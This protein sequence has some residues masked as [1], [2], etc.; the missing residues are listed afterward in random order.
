MAESPDREGRA[1]PGHGGWPAW[2]DEDDFDGL[3]EDAWL[4]AME[5]LAE[6]GP[7]PECPP[8]ASVPDA[9]AS[10]V[11]DGGGRD[12]GH[13]DAGQPDD[14]LPD[15]YL[16]DDGLRGGDGLPGGPG[17]PVLGFGPGDA[18][19]LMPPG[20]SLG[21][22]AE[23]AVAGGG[24]AVMSDYEVIG[25]AAAARRQR[26]RSD[27]LELQAIGEFTRRRW[28]S[29]ATAVR[30]ASGRWLF[31]NSP[32]EHAADE[33]AFHLADSRARAGDRM[34]LSVALRDRLPRLDALLA[35]GRLDDR[36][37]QAVAD[38]TAGLTQEQ[39]RQVDEM[40]APDA[41]GL[42]YT[43]VRRRAAKLA[44]SLS[45]EAE[46]KRK[47]RATRRKARVEKFLEKSGNYALAVR[48]MPVEEVLASQAHIRALADYLR[49]HGVKL[50]QR[51]AEV[52]VYLDLTQGRDPLDRI[53]PDRREHA[54][55]GAGPRPS[56]DSDSGGHDRAGQQSTGQDGGGQESTGQE[57]GQQDCEEWRDGPWD[58]YD[59]YGEDD[60]GDDD[61]NGGGSDGGGNGSG[62]SDGGDGG[63]WP[64]APPGPARPGGRAPFPATINLLVPVGAAFGWSSMPGEAGRDIID[65]RTLRE[66]TQAASR[67]PQ[68]RWCVTLVGKDGTAVAHGCA[69][70]RHAWDPPPGTT[71]NAAAASAG[72]G[73]QPTPA[74]AAA[75]AQFLARLKITPQ[76]IAKGSCDHRHAEP[77]Y[78]PSQKLG[79]LTRARNATCPAPGCEASSWHS[80]MDHTRPWPQGPTDECN[81]GLP[82]RHHHRTKQAP[83][84]KLE[85]PE[86]GAFRWTTPS[87]HAYETRPTTYDI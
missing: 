7:E 43:A 42:G 75:L 45:P 26:N 30:D 76:P 28:E 6:E 66:M 55:P 52:M 83:G 49:R 27:W 20:V 22:L 86:P 23:H 70:G 13:D 61:G 1:G 18:G 10:A 65:P 50:G 24:L 8:G 33:L 3:G 44:M 53:P 79:H 40:L 58:D 47:E 62:G 72:P 73:G 9:L 15:G 14:Y 11:L 35:A 69:R 85:Q 16:P 77:R 56:H 63:P 81:I 78:R 5:A 12:R 48:E 59:D 84:W 2:L 17:W 41:P 51:E 19:E 25:L 57:Q 54:G 32:A 71:G 31:R 29:G 87:G 82:C 60:S 80:D 21:M 37:V 39:A 64:F 46:R 38:I 34:E 4:A 74:Q 67:H 68:T 36:R